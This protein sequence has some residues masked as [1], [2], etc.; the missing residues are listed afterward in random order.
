MSDLTTTYKLSSA[1]PQRRRRR[2]STDDALWAATD[3]IMADA[4][5]TPT[6]GDEA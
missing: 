2:S 3:R 5:T 1:S 4:R 6:E